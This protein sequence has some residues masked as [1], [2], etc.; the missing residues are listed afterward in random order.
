MTSGLADYSSIIRPMYGAAL[1]SQVFTLVGASMPT[2]LFAVYGKGMV[3]G[4]IL[5][6]D[7]T[8]TQKSGLLGFEVDGRHLN[9]LTFNLLNL[10]HMVDPGIYPLYIK[11]FDDVN[12]VYTLG[13]SYGITFESKVTLTYNEADATTPTV[14]CALIY[15]L[16]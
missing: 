7:Y 11:C 16:L 15:A 8:S 13:F 14:L 6:V 5:A 9:A 1:R 4:G 2:P 10:Y 3:Y 12:F